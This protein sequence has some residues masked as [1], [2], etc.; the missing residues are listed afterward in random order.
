MYLCPVSV[1]ETCLRDIALDEYNPKNSSTLGNSV[2][3]P[4]IRERSH[5]IYVSLLWESAP[6]I[7]ADG[8]GRIMKGIILAGGKSTRL[9]PLTLVLSEQ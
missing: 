3:L 7:D 9:Y 2:G 4:F 5:A 8:G 1:L 6:R